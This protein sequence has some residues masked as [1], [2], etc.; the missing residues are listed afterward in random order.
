MLVKSETHKR[1]NEVKYKQKQ[2]Y[3]QLE[4]KIARLEQVCQEKEDNIK[5][6]DS[7]TAKQYEDV[8]R[9]IEAINSIKHKV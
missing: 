4:E 9:A 3:E 5:I 1:L 8:V 7:D 6:L 2:E